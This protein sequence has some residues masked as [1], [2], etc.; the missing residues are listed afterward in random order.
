MLNNGITNSNLYSMVEILLLFDSSFSIEN[1][2]AATLERNEEPLTGGKYY[3]VGRLRPL[4]LMWAIDSYSIGS[5]TVNNEPCLTR[6]ISLSTGTRLK[7]FRDEV[8]KRDGRCVITGKIA[9]GA[10]HDYWKGFQ[11]AHIFPLAYE[12][13]WVQQ[14]FSRWITIP[15][16]NGDNINSKQNG[17][18]LRSDIH[19]LFDVYDVS[20]N[21]DV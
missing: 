13:H 17:L 2:A 11:A 12:G 8:R 15:A 3:I 9:P 4:I 7:P 21:P 16:A 20:I 5:F 18:L 14:K 1:E 10:H 6:T 19:E